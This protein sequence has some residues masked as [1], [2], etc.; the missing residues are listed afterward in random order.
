MT[1]QPYGAPPQ[2]IDVFPDM[3]LVELQFLQYLPIFM[4]DVSVVRMPPN[5]FAIHDFRHMLHA[6]MEDNGGLEKMAADGLYVYVTTR[7]GFAT[8]GNPLNRPGWHCDGFGTQDLNYIWWNR[9]GTR[10]AGQP[11]FN[12]DSGHVKSMEQ[13]EQQLDPEKVYTPE[14]GGLYR[15]TPF[16]VHTTPEIPE[17]GGMRQFIKFSVSPHRYNLLGNTHNYLFEYD[18]KMYERDALRNDPAYGE[19]DYVAEA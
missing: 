8:P 17:P 10:F 4:P 19:Q 18:W 6:V 11:F 7:H 2:L 13:F 15:L 1:T 3:D 12:I 5:L 9:W 16:V 14:T